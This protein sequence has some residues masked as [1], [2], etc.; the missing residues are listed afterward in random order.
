MDVTKVLHVLLKITGQI[1]TAKMID[2]EKYSPCSLSELSHCGV[3]S[4]PLK[5]ETKM[6]LTIELNMD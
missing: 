3:I 1:Y 2:C 6:Y 5:T 4:I